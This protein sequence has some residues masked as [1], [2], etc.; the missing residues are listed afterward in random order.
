MVVVAEAA[1]LPLL[2]SGGVGE[3]TIAVLLTVPGFVGKTTMVI[4][5]ELPSQAAP[6]CRSRCRSSGRFSQPATF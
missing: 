1:L 3:L 2:G 4:V 5:A 6:S